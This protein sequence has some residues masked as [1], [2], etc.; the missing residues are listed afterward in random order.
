[1]TRFALSAT[2][3]VAVLTSTAIALA[4]PPRVAVPPAPRAPGP[5]LAAAVSKRR[6]HPAQ[7]KPP[8]PD[9]ATLAAAKK[10]V[11]SAPAMGAPMSGAAAALPAPIFLSQNVL[12]TAVRTRT[13]EVQAQIEFLSPLFVGDYQTDTQANTGIIVDYVGLPTSA[14]LLDCAI[15]PVPGQQPA[16]SLSVDLM[17]QDAAN[18]TI[19][20]THTDAVPFWGHVYVAVPAVAAADLMILLA[21]PASVPQAQRVSYCM[22]H[23]VP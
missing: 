18:N 21:V 4:E 9:D 2:A 7:S 5:Q 17:W 3:L 14:Y 23:S 1:M 16:A 22:L 6:P 10:Q 15:A 11:G 8:L 20:S 13:G 12:G 19:R